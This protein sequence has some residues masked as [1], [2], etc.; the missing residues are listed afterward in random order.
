M[1]YIYMYPSEASTHRPGNNEFMAVSSSSSKTTGGNC[2][3]W[4]QNTQKTH[5]H[6]EVDDIKVLKAEW[7]VM[8]SRYHAFSYFTH[9]P[10]DFCCAC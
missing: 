3:S 8:L 6:I 7:R 5:T 10:N 9:K 1:L 2:G 4:E